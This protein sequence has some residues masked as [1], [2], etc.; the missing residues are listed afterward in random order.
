MSGRS[1]KASFWVIMCPVD[2]PAP[3]LMIH[4]IKRKGG[5]YTCI[6]RSNDPGAAP[7]EPSFSPEVCTLALLVLISSVALHASW[8]AL[9]LFSRMFPA[10]FSC[11]L[12][13]LRIIRLLPAPPSSVP[14]LTPTFALM[15]RLR[16]SSIF[17]LPVE[18]SPSSHQPCPQSPPCVPS[19][20]LRTWAAYI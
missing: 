14:P 16:C 19:P 8:P 15:E 13:S 2:F 7:P 4:G 17:L 20:F 9:S 18:Y 11:P 12:F 6:F 3:V 5:V 1:W 10:V